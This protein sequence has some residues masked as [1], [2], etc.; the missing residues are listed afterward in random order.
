MLALPFTSAI[1]RSKSSIE[2]SAQPIQYFNRSTQALETEAVYGENYLHWTYGRAL[3]RLSLDALVKRAAFSRWY[4]WRMNQSASRVKILPFIERYGLDPG[5][6]AEAPESFASFNQFF[7]RKLD[8]VCRPLAGGSDIAV[9]P[10]DGRHFG[11]P[12]VSAID[13]F[14][15]KGT[16]F[17]LRKFLQN[18][19]LAERYAHGTMIFSRLCPVDY[20]RFHFPVSGT[21][22][23]MRRLDGC[24][25]SVNPIALRQ[26]LAYLWENKRCLT[27]IQ[28]D[29]FGEVLICPIGATCV[30]SIIATYEANQLMEKGD[31]MGYFAFGG[32]SIIVLFE[33]GRLTLS[34]DLIEWS[35]QGIEVYAKIGEEMGQA[36]SSGAETLNSKL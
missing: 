28:T 12:D 1:S 15:V 32:S 14:Y 36:S 31:E 30:G 35:C 11:F 17:D 20:H 33:P 18:D 4:G 23:P 34:N 6:F 13:G 3:G 24:L 26:R 22:G 10:A 19:A 8:P 29:V 21:P 2:L 27:N 5:E 9:F 7:Y 16:R 25:Y